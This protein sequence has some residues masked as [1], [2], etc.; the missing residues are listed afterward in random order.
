MSDGWACFSKNEKYRY[1]LGRHISD[2]P[3]RLLFVML[4][5]STADEEEP[6]PTI[7]KCMEIA[8]TQGFGELEVVN[9]YA[10]RTP[11]PSVLWQSRKPIGA[12]NDRYIREA[13]SRANKVILAWGYRVSEN[14][15][16]K[17]RAH[18]VMRMVRKFTPRRPYHLGFTKK[19][20]PK[21]PLYL[22]PSTPLKRWTKSQ[23]AE[24]LQTHS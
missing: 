12:R 20:E 21:H 7:N 16:R 19:K 14:V 24:Y 18:K 10:F 2:S 4:N 3:S 1:L 11:H 15:K 22:P 23:I 6:D 5:P 8:R 17:K 13:L 9:L